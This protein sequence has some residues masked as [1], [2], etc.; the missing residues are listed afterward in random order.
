MDLAND[1]LSGRP[2]GG[3]CILYRKSLAQYVNVI[4]DHYTGESAADVPV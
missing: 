3:T 4:A 2:Y 1:I